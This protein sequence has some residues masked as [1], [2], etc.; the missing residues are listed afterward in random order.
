MILKVSLFIPL[1]FS[2][3]ENG[4]YVERIFIENL[5]ECYYN[6]KKNHLSGCSYYHCKRYH[7]LTKEKLKWSFDGL[8]PYH[9][10]WFFIFT[11]QSNVTL[12][13]VFLKE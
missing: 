1:I 2:L 9:N 10:K 3:I 13:P 4:K 11:K 12:F 8:N 7:K 5:T 6:R